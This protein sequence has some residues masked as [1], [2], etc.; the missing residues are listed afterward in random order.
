MRRITMKKFLKIIPAIIIAAIAV[1]SA[2][3]ANG[4]NS[5]VN[6]LP[7][8]TTR[9]CETGITKIEYP[10]GFDAEC[11]TY[12]NGDTVF[13]NDLEH[14]TV[15]FSDGTVKEFA[16]KKLNEGLYV[17]EVSCP[18]YDVTVNVFTGLIRLNGEKD[19]KFRTLIFDDSFGEIEPEDAG[20]TG[21]ENFVYY[22]RML[23][24]KTVVRYDD[25]F[26]WNALHKLAGAADETE[27][28]GSFLMS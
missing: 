5:P 23:I 20:T 21:F 25:D 28:Y 1:F 18:G 3:S 9:A 17:T 7:I 27:T 14:L 10:D 4:A 24:N 15:T 16:S 6:S 8:I 26:F 12:Y 13:S 2:F 19:K 22:L 11:K